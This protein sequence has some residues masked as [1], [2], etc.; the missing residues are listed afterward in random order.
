MLEKRTLKIAAISVND[1]VKKS[2]FDSK[3]GC[4][5]SLVD[6]I[7]RATAVMLAGEVAVVAGYGDVSKGS[8]QSLDSYGYRVLVS[9]M[10]TASSCW[11]KA[12]WCT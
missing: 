7:K 8:A 1:C 5:E 3:Y 12:A 9:E 2:K 10:V 4:L 6:S 11:P